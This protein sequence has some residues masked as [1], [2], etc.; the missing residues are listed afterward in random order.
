MAG[1][2]L[3]LSCAK[4]FTVIANTSSQ[5]CLDPS[6]NAFECDYKVSEKQITKSLKVDET[7]VIE[8]TKEHDEADE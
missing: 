4:C 6:T 8:K 5:A 1:F 3:Q 7:K 2:S